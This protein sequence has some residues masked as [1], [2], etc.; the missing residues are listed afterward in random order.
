[1]TSLKSWMI[2][3]TMDLCGHLFHNP[4]DDVEMFAKMQ[5]DLLAA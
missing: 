4:E 3:M 2:D 5:S 1:M